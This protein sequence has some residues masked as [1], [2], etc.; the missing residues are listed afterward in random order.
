MNAKKKYPE[1]LV[2]Y[3]RYAVWAGEVIDW[4]GS[5]DPTK[6]IDEGEAQ[7]QGALLRDPLWAIAEAAVEKLGALFDQECSLRERRIAGDAGD[8]LVAQERHLQTK[9]DAIVTELDYGLNGVEVELC[10]FRQFRDSVRQSSAALD[11]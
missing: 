11:L 4:I 1:P 7:D 6:P 8:M 10:R 9:I 3:E 2:E 5:S